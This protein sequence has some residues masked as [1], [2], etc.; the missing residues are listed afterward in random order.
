M[1]QIFPVDNTDGESLLHGYSSLAPGYYPPQTEPA[2]HYFFP[3]RF[4]KRSTTSDRVNP[5]PV[6]VPADIGPV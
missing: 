4:S 5:V 6:A 1:K 3:D 2:C